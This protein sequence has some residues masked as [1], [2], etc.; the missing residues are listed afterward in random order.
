MEKK[1]CLWTGCDNKE[2]Q[3]CLDTDTPIPMLRLIAKLEEDNLSGLYM[4]G[5]GHPA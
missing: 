3:D 4:G 5:K 2:A 1:D